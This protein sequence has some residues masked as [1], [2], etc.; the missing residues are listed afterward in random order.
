MN[1]LGVYTLCYDE[2]QAIHFAYNSLRDFYPDSPIYLNSESNLDF[3]FLKTYFKKIHIENVEDTQS[4]I[5]KFKPGDHV[6]NENRIKNKNAVI[7]LISRLKKAFEFLQSD[8]VIMHCPDTLVRNKLTIPEGSVLLGSNVN[9]YFF[10]DVNNVISNYGGSPISNFGA[11]P[12]IFNVQKFMDCL[13]K[14]ESNMKMLDDLCSVF[15]ACH[16]H[17]II[18]PIIFSLGHFREEFNPDITECTRNPNW[19]DSDHSL[20]HQFRYFYPNRKTKYSN[21]K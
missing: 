21:E 18:I 3:N 20:L 19:L 17:D 7:N 9:N 4:G 12:A 8:Y 5:F 13:N 15:Y 2:V 11:V 16:S 10:E 1:K 6:L 14:F